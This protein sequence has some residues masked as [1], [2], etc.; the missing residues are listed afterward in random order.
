MISIFEDIY[1]YKSEDICLQMIEWPISYRGQHLIGNPVSNSGICTLWTD[2]KGVGDKISK[3]LF[4]IAGQCYGEVEGVSEII[5]NCLANKTIRQI[6]V[7][8]NDLSSSGEVLMSL[9]SSRDLK[10]REDIPAEAIAKFRQNV[11]MID[12]R[13]QSLESLEDKLRRSSIIEPWGENEIYERVAPVPPKIFPSEKTGIFVRGPKIGEVWLEILDNLFKFGY[14]KPSQYAD[15]QI[16]LPALTSIITDENPDNF[17]WHPAF[18]YF[19]AKGDMSRGMTKKSLKHY[20]PQLLTANK[21]KG[22]NYTYGALLRDH[23]GIDQIAEMKAHLKKDFFSRRAVGVTWNVAKDYNNSHAPCLDLVQ[24]LVQ[25]NSLIMTAYMRS[26]DMF[27]A[28][29]EN[30][31]AFRHVQ[32]EIADYIGADLGDLV[33]HSNS[34]HAYSSDWDAARELLEK[35]PAY[36]RRRSPD[37]RGNIL[38]SVEPARGIKVSHYAPDGTP[39]QEFYAHNAKGAYLLISRKKIISQIS[40]ALDIGVELGKAETAL[41]LGKK[42]SQD[43][44][45][46]V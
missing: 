42:Y 45:L 22:V 3:D 31:A 5:R 9:N 29:P 27:K 6:Y 16:E 46:K 18:G 10:L 1:F 26:H 21:I 19:P 34:A 36:R 35:F 37:P 11:K 23:D 32:K 25:D 17:Y 33:V 39:L 43:K 41:V 38:I 8:G 28:Y 12:M 13:K 30:V 2:V 4:N 44:S 15:D 24:A 20:L 14:E 7:W 40:H